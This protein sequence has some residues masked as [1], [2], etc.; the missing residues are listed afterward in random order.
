MK[1]P[2]WLTNNKAMS[3]TENFSI[4]ERMQFLNEL[5]ENIKVNNGAKYENLKKE[6]T[7]KKAKNQK[8]SNGWH[9]CFDVAEIRIMG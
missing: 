8:T 2:E 6:S 5:I 4:T 7:M 3:L 1:A 9:V